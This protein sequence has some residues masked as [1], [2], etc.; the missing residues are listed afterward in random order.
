MANFCPECGAAVEGMRFCAACGAPL[1]GAAGQPPAA[2]K[3][4]DKEQVAILDREITAL[5]RKG[6]HIYGR[7]TPYEVTLRRKSGLTA[8]QFLALWV[9]EDGSLWTN[10]HG[11]MEGGRLR[12]LPTLFS[13]PYAHREVVPVPW[14]PTSE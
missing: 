1:G 14:T 8:R 3:L 2:K 13:D 6:W 10:Q 12:D 7:P 5:A 4:D 9:E 11:V